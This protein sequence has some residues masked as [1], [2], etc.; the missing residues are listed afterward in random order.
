VSQAVSHAGDQEAKVVIRDGGESHVERSPPDQPAA[1]DQDAPEAGRQGVEG[2]VDV[3]H[4][5][6]Q[7]GA[8]DGVEVARDVEAP[9]DDRAATDH[10]GICHVQ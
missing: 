3:V 4:P 6:H 8:E 5:Y 1:G 9:D 10:E 2:V 7:D